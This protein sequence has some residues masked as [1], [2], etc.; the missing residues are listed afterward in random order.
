VQWTRLPSPVRYD[1][2]LQ[3]AAAIHICPRTLRRD[4]AML[5]GARPAGVRSEGGGRGG[6]GRGPGEL[7]LLRGRGG[8]VPAPLRGLAEVVVLLRV[9]VLIRGEHIVRGDLL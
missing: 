1:V 9:E 2:L 5:R 7:L 4:R 8:H 6:G 3:V